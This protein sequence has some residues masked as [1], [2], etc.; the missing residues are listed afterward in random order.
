M[1]LLRS[2]DELP[3]GG[4]SMDAGRLHELARRW[5]GDRLAPE[6]SPRTIEQSQAILD[7]LGLTGLFWRL[8]T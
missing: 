4:A 3:E 6:W 8:D 7:V 2:G 5:H 1:V